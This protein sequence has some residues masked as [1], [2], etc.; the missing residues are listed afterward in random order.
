M[1]K[2]V[3]ILA[4]SGDALSAVTRTRPN[5]ERTTSANTRSAPSHRQLRA[6]RSAA[7]A[8]GESP[9]TPAVARTRVETRPGL[10]W[11]R[12]VLQVS[13]I[14]AVASCDAVREGNVVGRSNSISTDS[15]RMLC[16]RRGTRLGFRGS[17]LHASADG[18]RLVLGFILL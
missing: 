16:Y 9:P 10:R 14:A 1:S 18:C 5:V 8:I 11:A 6:N 7:M 17:G 12:P 4:S 15:I 2:L 13:T 3:K